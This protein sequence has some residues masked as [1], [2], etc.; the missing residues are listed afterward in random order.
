[1]YHVTLVIGLCYSF[2]ERPY[3]VTYCFDL[4]ILGVIIYESYSTAFNVKS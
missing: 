4:V 1:M 2:N 3:C